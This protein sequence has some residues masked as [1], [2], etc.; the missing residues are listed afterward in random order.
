MKANDGG[1]SNG[2]PPRDRQEDN[3]ALPR[4]GNRNRFRYRATT[5][6]VEIEAD[7]TDA[8]A[9]SFSQL[10]AGLA[11]PAITGQPVVTS[12]V[13]PVVDTSARLAAPASNGTSETDTTEPDEAEP[14]V[15]DSHNGQLS[16]VLRPIFTVKD[17]RLLF[18]TTAL[19]A[20]SRRDYVKR[21]V[22]LYLLGSAALGRPSVPRGDITEVLKERRVYDGNARSFLSADPKLRR[23]EDSIELTAESRAEAEQ[24]AKDVS[25][26]SLPDKWRPG[27]QNSQKSTAKRAGVSQEDAG[28]PQSAPAKSKGS[29]EG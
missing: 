13:N 5:R 10:L 19:K 3:A 16:Q 17:D 29:G 15:V 11:S 6:S 1:P 14:P 21:A 22:Y 2:S 28:G 4:S 23:D 20:K 27:K 8:T 26:S 25:D 9:E 7:F 18:D 12:N 24:Y